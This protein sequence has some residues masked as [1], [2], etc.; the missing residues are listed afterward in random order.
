MDIAGLED[1][2][3]I[4]TWTKDGTVIGLSSWNEGKVAS[5]DKS[6]VYLYDR[7][8]QIIAHYPVF[9]HDDL[10]FVTATFKT[11]DDYKKARASDFTSSV[12]NL[13]S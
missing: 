11:Y 2:R 13:G 3:Y 1:R 12:I 10:Y 8:E 7:P 6:G 5:T 9:V 4:F